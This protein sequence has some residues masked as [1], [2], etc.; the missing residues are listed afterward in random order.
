M[1]T[2][3]YIHVYIQAVYIKTLGSYL[4]EKP[5]YF[6]ISSKPHFVRKQEEVLPSFIASPHT[7]SKFLQVSEAT[8]YPPAGTNVTPPGPS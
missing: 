8:D 1:Y 7:N 4:D 6:P 3:V 2:C 5:Q